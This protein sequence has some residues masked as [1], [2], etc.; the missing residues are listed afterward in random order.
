MRDYQI[1]SDSSCDLGPELANEKRIDIIPFYVSFDGATYQK[2][3]VE[4]S[5]E[6]FYRRVLAEPKYSR[7]LLF[8]R[9]VISPNASVIM[10]NADSMFYAS[11]SRPNSAV[12]TTA[13]ALH[14]IWYWKNIRKPTLS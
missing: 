4:L 5:I 9:S 11:V 14:G 1:I 13:P 6:D 8:R 7:R 10:L 2:E 12:R 3:S